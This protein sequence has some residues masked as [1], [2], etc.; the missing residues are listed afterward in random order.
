MSDEEIKSLERSLARGD[1]CKAQYAEELVRHGGAELP[2]PM[3]KQAQDMILFASA[4][5]TSAAKPPNDQAAHV[6]ATLRVLL[7]ILTE[8]SKKHFDS[9]A[10]KASIEAAA[11]PSNAPADRLARFANSVGNV[12]VACGVV[13]TLSMLLRL[14]SETAALL[15]G[16]LGGSTLLALVLLGFR[17]A[18]RR[19]RSVDR[20]VAGLSRLLATI[21]L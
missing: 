15:F 20:S 8:A 2:L 7:Q 3:S 9:A 19:Q 21:R 16:T 5:A 1:I 13:L 6:E 4:V 10:A 18:L 11:R 17:D 14:V 12:L